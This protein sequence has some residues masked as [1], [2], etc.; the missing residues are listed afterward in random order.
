MEIVWV[1]KTRGNPP[2]K[3]QV[4]KGTL[5]RDIK[6]QSKLPLWICNGRS[7]GDFVVEMALS[8]PE[9]PIRNRRCTRYY[10]RHD[11]CFQILCI[12]RRMIA[13]VPYI[14]SNLTLV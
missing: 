7:V 3:L 4:P 9:H 11:Q 14:S 1:E 13:T 6:G 12:G 2:E 5:V 10:L 8:S